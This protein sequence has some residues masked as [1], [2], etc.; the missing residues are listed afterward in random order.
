MHI[1]PGPDYYRTV[2][3]A[4][5]ADSADSPHA[6]RL[7]LLILLLL[8]VVGNGSFL[9]MIGSHSHHLIV[10]DL[11]HHFHRRR[12]HDPCRQFTTLLVFLPEVSVNGPAQR[13]GYW[14]GVSV[15]EF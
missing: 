11:A 2:V 12:G 1:H 3:T 8:Q 13:Q 5:G 4:V 9:P 7:M 6:P 14:F 10:V 15:V